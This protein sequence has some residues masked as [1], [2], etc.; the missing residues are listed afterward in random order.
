VRRAK[1]AASS[2]FE[3]EIAKAVEELVRE[4]KRLKQEVQTLK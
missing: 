4:V 1:S 2:T 3:S